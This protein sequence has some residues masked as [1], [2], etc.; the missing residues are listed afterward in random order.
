MIQGEGMRWDVGIPLSIVFAY[1]HNIQ[2]IPTENGSKIN[3]ATDSVPLSQFIGSLFLWYLMN[4]V[5]VSKN[6]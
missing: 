2:K 1:S 5:A 6:D 3:F 4:I